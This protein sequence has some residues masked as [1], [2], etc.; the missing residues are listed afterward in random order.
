MKCY[1]CGADSGGKLKCQACFAAEIDALIRKVDRSMED[2]MNGDKKVSSLLSQ[3]ENLTAECDRWRTL[4]WKLS[5]RESAMT[6]VVSKKLRKEVLKTIRSDERL[7]DLLG[8]S[9]VTV[10]LAPKD[11]D[12]DEI[13]FYVDCDRLSKREN[14]MFAGLLSEWKDGLKQ[15]IRVESP[16]LSKL[17]AVYQ[18]TVMV[19]ARKAKK[20]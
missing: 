4:S 18:V 16:F 10:I 1:K 7:N 11:D 12:D 20:K 5:L 2:E 14:D 17:L 13:T 3:V 9:Q 19:D 15:A 8:N 6:S